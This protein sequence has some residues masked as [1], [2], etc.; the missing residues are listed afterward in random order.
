MEKTKLEKLKN[1]RQEIDNKI[2][3]IERK[4]SEK[5]LF[6]RAKEVIGYC[7]RF[8]NKYI[9]DSN[10]W[11][12]YA[13]VKD[14][15]LVGSSVYM[16]LDTYEITKDNE[17]KIS[18]NYMNLESVSPMHCWQYIK[19]EVFEENKQKILSLIN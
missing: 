4:E 8:N 3:E 15:V 18:I 11:Y 19:K 13:I 1:K 2:K 5:K 16:I 17:I 6:K 9:G 12:I 10:H 7:Y 14:A